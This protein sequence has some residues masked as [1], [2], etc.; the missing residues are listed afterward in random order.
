MTGKG[1][2]ELSPVCLWQQQKSVV[3]MNLFTSGQRPRE[4]EQAR[5][6][7]GDTG[8]TLHAA[9][10]LFLLSSSSLLTLR[11]YKEELEPSC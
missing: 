10:V 1:K 9:P 4:H 2:A 8:R 6:P 3:A 7:D 5:K 11:T